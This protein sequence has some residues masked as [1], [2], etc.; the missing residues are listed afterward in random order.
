MLTS[1]IS[2]PGLACFWKEN[3]S[4]V[5]QQDNLS[6]GLQVRDLSGAGLGRDVKITPGGYSLEADGQE[7]SHK[8]GPFTHRDGDSC[9]PV[10]GE[11]CEGGPLVGPPFIYQ[12]CLPMSP[13][14]PRH[15]HRHT[16]QDPCPHLFMSPLNI[17]P[18][19]PRWHTGLD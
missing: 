18:V 4:T 1:A 2:S 16:G 12:G 14:I 7:L 10:R 5:A 6:H 13:L 15:L 17:L 19:L 8:V 11:K 9:K 3:R